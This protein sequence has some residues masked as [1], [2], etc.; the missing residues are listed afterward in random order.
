MNFVSSL[1]GT[2]STAVFLLIVIHSARADLVLLEDPLEEQ[3]DIEEEFHDTTLVTVA[4]TVLH[5]YL[6][7]ALNAFTVFVNAMTCC[8]EFLYCDCFLTNYTN[9]MLFTISCAIGL[10][11]NYPIAQVMTFSRAFIRYCVCCITTVAGCRF[12]SVCCA[13]C[14]IV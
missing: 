14:I 10:F 11:V 8:R 2:K 6:L 3:N 5:L 9:L 13:S 1:G 12:C 7:A 4:R